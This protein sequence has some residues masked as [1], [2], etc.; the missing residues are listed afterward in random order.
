MHNRDRDFLRPGRGSF[1]TPRIR[2]PPRARYSA[3]CD[4]RC[5]AGTDRGGRGV[6]RDPS[7]PWPDPAAHSFRGPTPRNAVMFGP[8]GHLYVYRR[9]RHALLRQRHVRPDGVAGGVL[10]RGRGSRRR[11]RAR[12]LA[13]PAVRRPVDAARGPGNLGAAWG[14]TLDDD[15]LDLFRRGVGG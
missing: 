12:G 9:L 15:G 11:T 8:P 7:G 4:C 1:A 14:L 13:G 6:R 5:S 3:G 10:L 2:S